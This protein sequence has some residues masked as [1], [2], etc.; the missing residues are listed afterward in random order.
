MDKFGFDSESDAKSKST[1]SKNPILPNELT[2][3]NKFKLE[4]TEDELNDEDD[5]Y[6]ND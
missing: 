6:N 1:K 4:N 5:F 3:Q 2:P